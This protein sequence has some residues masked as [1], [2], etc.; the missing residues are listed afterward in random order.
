MTARSPEEWA[1]LLEVEAIDEATDLSGFDAGPEPWARDITRFLQQDALYHQR[2]SHATATYLF[3]H[4]DLLAGYV[5]L[6][7][8]SIPR[9]K[10][11]QTGIAHRAVR[12]A[13]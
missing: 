9:D 8:D 6:A 1:G 10:E 13:L 3:F 7:M 2:R 11:L 4:D 12:G 5:S